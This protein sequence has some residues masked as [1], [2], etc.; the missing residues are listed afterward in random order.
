VLDGPAVH[1]PRWKARVP[2][3]RGASWDFEDTRDH[4]FGRLFGLDPARVR[5]DDA[6]LYLDL[7]R[8][9][10]GEVMAQVFAE[11][12]RPGSTCA[13]GLVWLLQD[14]EIGAGWGLVDALGRP[15]PAWWSLARTLR[16][17]QALMTDEGVNG[18]AVHVLNE[19]AAPLD[20]ALRLAVFADH[21]GPL[22]EVRRSVALGPREGLT[23]SAFELIGR[24]FDLTYAYRF[25]PRDH[26]AVAAQLWRPDGGLASQ[27]V[28]LPPGVQA[29]QAGQVQADLEPDG[30]GWR[31]T[32]TAERLLRFVKVVDP[33]FA[34]DDDWLPLLPGEPRKLR[35]ARRPEALSDARPAGEL[36]SAGGQLVGSYRA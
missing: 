8:V 10:T 27:A 32:L 33:N 7:S 14:P 11:W 30:E 26:V 21:A 18:L 24:F 31:L 2:R 9:V 4:Y 19:T 20:A 17:V 23:L 1:D 25:G 5:R 34:P 16:P 3:D 6:E 36:L 29:W 13:G 15:K 35:L 22:I 12:R 28:Y